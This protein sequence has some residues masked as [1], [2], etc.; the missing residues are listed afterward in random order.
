MYGYLRLESTRM[1]RDV[2]FAVIGLVSPLL[3]YMVISNGAT[4]PSRQ[5]TIVFLTVTTRVAVAF[6]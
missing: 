5:D 3:M 4:G 2:K 1:F 6:R